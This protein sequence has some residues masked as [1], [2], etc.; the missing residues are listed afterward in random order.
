MADK[1]AGAG[2][3]PW[4]A[5]FADLMALMMCFFVLL[6]SFSYLDEVKYKAVV[7]SMAKGFGSEVT[8]VRAQSSSSIGPPSLVPNTMQTQSRG[9]RPMTQQEANKD[10]IELRRKIQ[11][12]LQEQ[13]SE[14]KLSVEMAGNNVVI[15]F[16][17][18]IAFPPGSDAI[19]D[20]LLPI[21][22]RVTEALADEDGTIQVSGHTDDRP[23]STATIKSNWELSTKRAVAVIHMIEQLGTVDPSQLTAVGYSDTR[24]I[25]PNDTVEGRG[26]NRRVEIAVIRD[27]GAGNPIQPVEPPPLP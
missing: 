7:A 5:T 11:Q 19:S 1:N 15:R 22:A 23:I 17:E 8:P 24:P 2:I 16:P 20:E 14:G 3:P 6:Y 25:F 18:E 9:A 10:T 13:I 26:R 4:M 21:L 27:G 12:D